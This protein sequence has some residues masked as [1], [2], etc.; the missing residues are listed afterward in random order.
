MKL[1]ESTL[2][3]HSH[4][5]EELVGGATFSAYPSANCGWW[6]V[7]L[8]WA[9]LFDLLLS[10]VGFWLQTDY[11]CRRRREKKKK[12]KKVGVSHGSSVMLDDE[13][14]WSHVA[15]GAFETS[16]SQ[17]VESDGSETQVHF[18]SITCSN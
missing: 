12:K 6:T 5:T 1:L 16:A 4:T 11:S 8:K 7:P 13:C 15:L 2:V 18:L 17:L 10:P 3:S 14:G 9:W